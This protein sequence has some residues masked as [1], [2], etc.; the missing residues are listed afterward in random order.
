VEQRH[1]A[2]RGWRRKGCGRL[3]LIYA[4]QTRRW[5]IAPIRDAGPFGI[6]RG[7]P[8]PISKVKAEGRLSVCTSAQPPP[9]WKWRGVVDLSKA[10]WEDLGRPRFLTRVH[11]IFL[12][13]QRRPYR[14][15][16]PSALLQVGTEGVENAQ[17]GS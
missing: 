14:P 9:G 17:L 4:E 12:P 15:E 13:R 3:V 6:Y 1:I 10:L 11:L 2:Y 16:V 7:R 5:A 8:F